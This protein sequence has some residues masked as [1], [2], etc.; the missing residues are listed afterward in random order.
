M[1]ARR[2]AASSIDWAAF[3]ARVPEGQKAMFNAFKG[4]SD[5]YLRR[6][7]SLPETI[8]KIQ[9]AAYQARI[10]VPGM[11]DNF[12]KQYEALEVPYPA[13]T[14]SGQI[15]EIEKQAAAETEVFVKQSEARIV[16]LKEE[17]VKWENMVPFEQMT[18][19]EY[20]EQFPDE[21]INLDKPTLWPHT[22]EEQ[23]GYVPKDGTET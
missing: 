22:P 5:T 18:M 9:F 23:I 10:D 3:A 14:V 19:E 2:I 6:V 1:A 16:K 17:L 12:K 11:V 15:T 4:K 8:P 13:D 21:A 20:A 7:L